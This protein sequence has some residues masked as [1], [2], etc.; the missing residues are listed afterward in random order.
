[1]THLSLRLRVFLFFGLMGLGGIAVVTGALVLGFR[2]LA[3]R[4]A[5]S[6]F[7]TVG[8]VA[9]LGILG[10]TAF[11][12][13]LFDENVSKPIET[14]AAA[15]RLRADGGLQ[16]RIDPQTAKY[17]GDLAPAACAINDKLA[18]ATQAT[19]E[20]VAQRTARLERQRAQ[21]LRILSDLPMAVIV[22]NPDHQ[23]VLYDGQAAALMECEAP[24]RL[25]GHVGD[26]LDKDALLTTLRTLQQDTA[27]RRP[28]AI[29]GKSG[30]LYY[31]HIRLFDD[32][33]G[34]MLMLEPLAADAARPL[35]YDF[36]LLGKAPV[37][38]PVDALLDN[39]TFVVFDSET[40][41]LDP[42]KDVVV[43]LGAVRVVNGRRVIGE[44]FE[45]LVNPRRAIPLRSTKV[46]G[47]SNAMVRD[48]PD[49]ATVRQQFHNF[50]Q[51]SVL[52]AHNASFDMA[53]LTR[54]GDAPIFA[55][56]V[57]DTVHLSAITFGGS[58]I[59][60]LDA[61][62]DRLDITIPPL[63]RHTAMGDAIATADIL[64]KLI[65]ILRARG[66]KT[67]GDIC[68]EARKHRRILKVHD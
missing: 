18:A 65:P 26:Y 15:F 5:L 11:V 49:F 32:D 64:V 43:Q 63:V 20:T 27:K 51:G 40:T 1:M 61:I 8:V 37:D 28:I 42:A 3:S 7:V 16:T 13:R 23:I 24:A 21:L 45:S 9:G 17:L 10:L 59:H 35:V 25:H 50:A 39:L 2:Q 30:T 52:V 14:L 46:H 58:A 31:G 47:I 44:A 36:D 6:A 60:T 56:P 62:C 34:Y 55:N 29:A 66:L 19:A 4:D 53:F 48:A 41:G 22:A 57:L 33:G 67:F 68:T 54:D 12:W 38:D